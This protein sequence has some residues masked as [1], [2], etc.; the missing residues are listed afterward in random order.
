MVSSQFSVKSQS[1]TPQGRFKD[2]PLHLSHRAFFDALGVIRALENS[3]DENA[4]GVHMIRWKR[5]GLDEFFYFR[6]HVVG[7]RGHHWV[8]IARCLAEKEVAHAVTLPSLDESKIS[9]QR[10]LQNEV[11]AIEFAGFLSLG[12]HS[13]IAS[14]RVERGNPSAARAQT[15]RK[16]AL[17]I[18]F[19]LQ[20]SAQNELLEQLVLANVGG[21]HFA[22]LAIL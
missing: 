22:D 5:T 21:D 19:Y 20:F 10:P 3:I 2:R 15:F 7:S 13:A 17:R 6:D 16:R 11:A 4:R 9:T 18:Q 8:E 1:Q 12:N 14:R